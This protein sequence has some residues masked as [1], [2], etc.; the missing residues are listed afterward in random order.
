[1]AHNF[2]NELEA[3]KGAGLLRTLRTVNSEQSSEILLNRRRVLLFCSN[4]YLG[5]ANREEL[6]RA[7]IEAI[8]KYG[9]GSGASRLVSGNMEIHEALEERIARFKGTESALLFNSGYHANLGVIPALA[10]E[11][12][13]ILSD[14]LN[15]ASI[16]D[17]CR[18]SRAQVVVYPHGDTNFVEDTLRRSKHRRKLIVTDGVFSMDG[19]IAP[20]IELVEIKE[21]YGAILMVDEAHATGVTGTNGRG[22]IDLFGLTG[23]VEVI[24]GTLGKALGTYGAYIATSKLLREYLINSARSFIFS[25]SLP[26]SVCGSAIKAF[27]LIEN[28]PELIAKLHENVSE[29]KE[30]LK[31][32]YHPINNNE[33]PIIPLILGDAEKTMRICEELLDDGIFIQGIRPPSVPK[34]TSRLR[35]TVTA[36]HTTEQIQKAV[37]AI[38][39]AFKKHH[40]LQPEVSSPSFSARDSA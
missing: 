5:L 23:R 28:E 10:G 19:D 3:L 33:I 30:G 36:I 26:P 6:K 24:M 13:L 22:V 18:L 16:I 32:F 17:G 1:M 25:T 27:D 35:L 14:E 9:T 34:G 15:H 8:E 21:R 11:G 29:L 2:Y 20:L 31:K 40:V 12:D 39:R 38:E 7:A 37:D 4:N